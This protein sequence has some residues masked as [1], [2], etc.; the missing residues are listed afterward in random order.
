LIHTR[1]RPPADQALVL[2]HFILAQPVTYGRQGRNVELGRHLRP[3]TAVANQAGISAI[4]EHEGKRIH[5]NG[6][7]GTGFA[8][9]RAK[10]G[11]EFQFEPVDEDEVTDSE[12]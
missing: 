10:T 11:S 12:T 4:T 3:I 5:Q 2:I 8:R 1:E 9:Q 7:A 6:F